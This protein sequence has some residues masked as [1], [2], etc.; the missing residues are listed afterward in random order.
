MP[1]RTLKLQHLVSTCKPF[2][3]GLVERLSVGWTSRGSN[4]DGGRG[5]PHLSRPALGPIQP[6]ANWYCFSFPELKRSGRIF[7]HPPQ[8]SADVKRMSRAIPLLPLLTFMACS[9]VNFTFFNT[10]LLCYEMRSLLD[11]FHLYEKTKFLKSHLFPSSGE[12]AEICVLQLGS[13]GRGF[14]IVIRLNRCI[15]AVIPENVNR[16]SIRNLV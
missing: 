11:F 1:Q 12:R 10:K 5:F 16:S 14:L 8:S 15:P 13:C 7:D 9:R 4:P 6:P 3:C 2:A